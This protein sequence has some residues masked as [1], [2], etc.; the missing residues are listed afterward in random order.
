MGACLGLAVGGERVDSGG[1][2]LVVDVDVCVILGVSVLDF[3]GESMCGVESGRLWCTAPWCSIRVGDSSFVR[4]GSIMSSREA[5]ELE[6]EVASLLG[7]MSGGSKTVSAGS[8]VWPSMTRLTRFR[9][10]LVAV[11]W[12]RADFFVGIEGRFVFLDTSVCSP[13]AGS[14]MAVCS[15]RDVRASVLLSSSPAGVAC[16]GM[17]AMGALGL[18]GRGF[19]FSGSRASSSG[20]KTGVTRPYSSF[21]R[22]CTRVCLGRL[23]FSSG[24]GVG[25]GATLSAWRAGCSSPAGGSWAHSMDRCCANSCGLISICGFVGGRVGIPLARSGAGPPGAPGYIPQ[26]HARAAAASARRRWSGRPA[27]ICSGPGPRPVM[28]RSAASREHAVTFAGSASGDGQAAAMAAVLPATSRPC[29]VVYLACGSAAAFGAMG[30]ESRQVTGRAGRGG[31]VSPRQPGRR[32]S[33][34]SGRSE[35]D[36]AGD[37]EEDAVQNLCLFDVVSWWGPSRPS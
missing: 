5:V 4:R 16:S 19:F 27:G 17:A 29:G 6:A 7:D 8:T 28:S 35:R 18:C 9:R 1:I 30:L 31:D 37:G 13:A 11:C 26:C 23:A 33:R 14:S 36:A 2:V 32:R 34:G 20:R 3:V 21:S 24:S 10:G 15:R 12:R 25:A 22:F